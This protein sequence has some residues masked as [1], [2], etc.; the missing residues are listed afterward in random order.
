MARIDDLLLV[1]KSGLL[2]PNMQAD[3]DLLRS[4]GIVPP[5]QGAPSSP[6]APRQEEPMVQQPAPTPLGSTQ[7]QPQKPG[8]FSQAADALGKDIPVLGKV[9]GALRTSIPDSI[10]EFGG[11]VGLPKTAATLGTA[12][13]LAGELIPKTGGEALA[14]AA[15][16]AI[17]RG[18]AKVARTA[19]PN[20]SSLLTGIEVPVIERAFARG[21]QIANKDLLDSA[22]AEKAI[23][24]LGEGLKTARRIA[25]EKLQIVEDR[26][27]ERNLG[28]AVKVGDIGD[29]LEKTLAKRGF[30]V[31][32][33]PKREV[34]RSIA[35]EV[36]EVIDDFKNATIESAPIVTGASNQSGAKHLNFSDALNLRRKIGDIV[37]FERK[38]ILGIDKTTGAILKEAYRELNERLLSISP[39]F[40]RANDSFA[41]LAK[42]YKD[43]QE[44]VFSGKIETIERRISQL[45]R[46][47]TVQ[48]KLM[49]KA[50]RISQTAGAN[51]DTILDSITA[52]R[53]DPII[54]PRTTR[55]IFQTGGGLSG[56]ALLGASALS[57]TTV[58]AAAAFGTAISP[59]ANL[60]AI[61][62]LSALTKPRGRSK[63]ISALGS[64]EAISLSALAAAR[65]NNTKERR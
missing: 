36:L 43:L 58:A 2:P 52:Q 48:R 28:R 18:A 13:S 55:A 1:E 65:K 14:A 64:P 32:G 26:I 45:F 34:T 40:K 29:K 22:A 49:E 35:R 50:D 23:L 10:A 24:S 19:L 8:L 12:V 59:R 53:F 47:G 15:L 11:R 27:A 46:K 61:K 6:M 42:S 41:A 54:N 30:R 63:A 16:P 60:A 62:T 39:E 17:G 21:K 20:L 7:Q 38:N 33:E 4:K 25:G 3:L 57:P 51:L 31:I 37:S 9:A 44:N 56:P 5:K